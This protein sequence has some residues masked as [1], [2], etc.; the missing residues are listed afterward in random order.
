MI[1]R[2]SAY[3]VGVVGATG[4]V[5]REIVSILNQ[6][7]FPLGRLEL[8]ASERSEGEVVEFGR[9]EVTVKALRPDVFEDLD[10]ALFSAGASVSREYAP[11]AADRDC[12][13]V[14]NSS[15]WRADP[16]VPLVVPEVNPEDLEDHE[17][18]GIV[19]NPN[20][21]TIQMVVAL[22]PIADQLGLR[23]VAVTTFQSVSGAGQ[24]GIDELS[25]QVRQLFNGQPAEPTVHKHQMAFNCIPHIGAFR[26]DGY[27]EEEWKLV[28]ETR[29]ILHM[30][31]LEVTPTAVRVPVFCGHCE[32]LQIQ[33]EQ[34]VDV[35]RVRELLA[36]APGI[37]V[38]DDPEHHVYPTPFGVTG[39]DAVRVGRIRRDLFREDVLCLWVVADNMRK[40]A[41]L[42]AVQILE[43]LVEE[44]W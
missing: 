34:H 25:G 44:P 14:D 33:T 35:E 1:E 18:K 41:A 24:K 23:R 6:R 4:A 17:E 26:E 37:E 32:S 11:E 2:K 39:K 38:L 9:R 43:L 29:R 5:G 40:G 36:A 42:N 22:K 21:S 10:V 15:A 3:S 12:V 13:V 31:D 28:A 20:C 8:F 19:A 7:N 30:P 16:L 27:T